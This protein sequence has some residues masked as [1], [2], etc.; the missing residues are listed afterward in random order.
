M[1]LPSMAKWQE[2]IGFEWTHVDAVGSLA[3]PAILAA[4]L[5]SSC[6]LFI[7]IT[8]VGRAWQSVPGLNVGHRIFLLLLGCASYLVVAWIQIVLGTA[9]YRLQTGLGLSTS[10]GL[11]VPIMPVWVLGTITVVA[12]CVIRNWQ[13]RHT[14][15]P[16]RG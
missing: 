13:K 3:D 16:E 10:L 4:T 1:S 8:K 2:E 14:N 6:L 5:V 11:Y 7:T 9:F 12:F 15:R